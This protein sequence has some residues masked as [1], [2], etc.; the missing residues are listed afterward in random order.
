[1][2]ITQQ[3]KEK[4]HNQ[5]LDEALPY[6]KQFGLAGAP[7]DRV[8]KQVGL[9]SGALYSHFK[10]KE[11]LFS[12]AI[13]RELD[14]LQSRLD[15]LVKDHG[16]AALLRFVDYYLNPKHILAVGEGCLFVALSTDM[17]KSSPTTKAIYEEKLDAIFNTLGNAF[18]K[19]S[20]E[21]KKS[22]V[23][24]IFSSLVG[25]LS[26]ARSMKSAEAAQNILKATQQQLRLYLERQ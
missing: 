12:Q 21:E 22:K 6:L 7:V 16:E 15:Q 25:T 4:L 10:S 2:R 17:R 20:A 5:I 23:Q 8:M 26:F 24:F 14:R 9:T 13:F 18:K 3:E 19:G 11:D 1:M